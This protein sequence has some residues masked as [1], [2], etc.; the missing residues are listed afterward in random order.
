MQGI[1]IPTGTA[2]PEVIHTKKYQI[3]PNIKAFS[4]R[5]SLRDDAI[6]VLMIFAC[7]SNIRVASLSKEPSGHKNCLVFAG[8][9]PSS[10]GA[11]KPIFLASV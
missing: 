11:P 9:T 8:S 4:I 10:G 6:N 2:V 1:N 3:H 7:E 5:I